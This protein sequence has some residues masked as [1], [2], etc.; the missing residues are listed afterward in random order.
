MT[1]LGRL[2][3]RGR[4]EREL[5]A[6]LQDHLERQVADY[7]AAG[8]TEAE[9]RRRARIAFGG[10]E[11]TKEDCRD[12][13]GTR[14]VEDL[15][16]DLRYGVRLLRRS[17]VFTTVA[18]ASLALGIGA[19]TAIFTLVDSLVLRSLPVHEPE[20]LV[21]LQHGSWTNPIWEEIRNR[22]R[23]LGLAAAA[24]SDTRFDLAD[25]GEARFAQGLFVSG[26]FFEVVGAST[27]PACCARAE[28]SSHTRL[29]NLVP[30][31]A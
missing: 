19:N 10:L 2:L 11:Q 28:A 26:G 14:L 27:R 30:S 18:I 17:P 6:E 29:R 8:M 5:Q 15:A 9:A 22:Q 16:Q 4:V 24:S 21:R 23:Q 12:A 31:T 1:W 13:R 3:R 25:G 20:R 7:V